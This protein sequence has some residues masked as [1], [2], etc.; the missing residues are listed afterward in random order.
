MTGS[1]AAVV[2]FAAFGVASQAVLVCFFIA[3]R[4]WAPRRRTLRLAC[5]CLCWARTA[6][7]IVA[8]DRRRLLE[9]L[10]GSAADG[11]VGA[12][13]SLRRSLAAAPVALAD[14]VECG[15]PVL[16]ALLLG[17]DVHVVAALECDASSLG[18]LP[19]AVRR[20]HRVEPPRALRRRAEQVR[21]TATSAHRTSAST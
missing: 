15:R 9:A 7:W 4:W 17:P 14:R 5:A 8:S 21:P 19:R 12:I 2:A 1:G 10:G 20:E 16:L 6:A 11:G 13:R 3:R 18:G